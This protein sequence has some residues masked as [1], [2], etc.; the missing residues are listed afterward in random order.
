MRYYR[1]D[2]LTRMSLSQTLANFTASSTLLVKKREPL[3]AGHY[4]LQMKR[5]YGA[6]TLEAAYPLAASLPP[7]AADFG[8][9]KFR[10]EGLAIGNGLTDPIAQARLPSAL[11]RPPSS[12]HT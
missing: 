3:G 2:E 6:K 4:I 12:H 1:V 10:L 11:F 5:L 7:N 8:P 9:P